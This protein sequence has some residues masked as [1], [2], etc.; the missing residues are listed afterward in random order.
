V[1]HMGGRTGNKKQS[2]ALWENEKRGDLPCDFFTEISS[3]P[4]MRLLY[5]PVTYTRCRPPPAIYR[6]ICDDVLRC[7]SCLE[8]PVASGKRCPGNTDHLVLAG[9]LL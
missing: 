8:A 6:H 1:L 3:S 2:K 7:V 9:I 5:T 4:F